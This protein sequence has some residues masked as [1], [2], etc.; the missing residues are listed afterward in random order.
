[1][2]ASELDPT[3]SVVLDT[4]VVLDWLLFRNVAVEPLAQ[5]V[6]HGAVRWIA[7]ARMHDELAATLAKPLLRRW[8]P[9]SERILTSMERHATRCA[10]PQLPKA[11]ALHCTDPDDQVFIDLALAERARWLVTRDRALLKLARRAAMR[12]LSIAPPERWP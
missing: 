3:P 2:P 11:L 8:N 1:M 4:N 6:E 7:S 5:A 9:D 10:E 12:G